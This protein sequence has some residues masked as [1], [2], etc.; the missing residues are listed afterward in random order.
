MSTPTPLSKLLAALSCVCWALST[1][2]A[3]QTTAP[4]GTVDVALRTGVFRGVTQ[5]NGPD[6]FLGIPFAQP[7]VGNLRF[8][9]PV[10]ITEPST[11]IFDASAFGD[12]CPQPANP[13]GLTLGAAIGE[14]CLRLN[15]FRPANISSDAK[16]PVM[17]WLHGGAYTINAASNPQYDPSDFIQ[18]S[19]AI[20]KPIVFVSS[21]YR[22]NTFG[23]LASADM[24]PEDLNA[25]LLDQRIALEF[26]QDNIAAFGGDPE[27]VTIWGQSS[28]A[29]SVE[30]HF[31]FPANRTLFRAGI[32]DSCTGPFKNSPPPSTFD[33][34][35][36]PFARLLEATG[37]AAGTG[38]IACLQAVPFDTLLNISNA[39]VSATLNH[40]LW[41]PSTGPAGNIAFEPASKRI[42]SGDFLH[43][44]FIGGTNVNDGTMFS[45]TLFG[46]GLSGQA[47]DDAFKNFIFNLVIDNA[48]LTNN[49]VDAFVSMYPANDP[50]NG[51][52][53]ATG[54]SLF[55][56]AAAWYTDTMFVAPRRFFFQ[57]AA[58]LQPM[59]AY[60]FGEFIQGNNPELGVAHQTELQMIFGADPPVSALESEFSTTFR[61]FYINFVNDL[62]PGPAWPRFSPESP[63]VLQLIR[64]NI[65]LIPD[66]F[67]QHQVDFSNSPLVLAELQ[68]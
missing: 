68:R 50:A 52:P 18:R 19:I 13:P 37:C 12:A 15:V 10:P 4:P 31:L 14:D 5:V 33:K 16:L 35:G 20:G 40:Q 28:G 44:P 39:M 27:K 22:L 21:N 45:T 48:T 57:R 26:V 24:P 7:P 54:D 53:F 47:E 2:A 38:A 34:P 9:A 61:D 63:K 8:K 25:G 64:D 11:E 51:A 65:T 55:D 17:V 56:R 42:N 46:L 6:K 49:V 59:F 66:T 41:E 67:N 1:P 23:F 60:L 58:N 36:K 3:A 29:G 62:N 32:A 30:A 43:L